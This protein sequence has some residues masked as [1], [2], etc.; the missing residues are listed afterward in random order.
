MLIYVQNINIF[1]VS[2]FYVS[3]LCKY[4][5]NYDLILNY[6]PKVKVLGE[7]KIVRIVFI[8]LR[9]QLSVTLPP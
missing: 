6:L 9:S 7:K 1:Y 8:H 3:I 4:I 2:K 5:Y